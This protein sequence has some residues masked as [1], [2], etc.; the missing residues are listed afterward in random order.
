[1]EILSYLIEDYIRCKG[2]LKTTLS[3]DNRI[4]LRERLKISEAKFNTTLSRLR[5]KKVIN[6]LG[7][8]KNYLVYPD[9]EGLSISF[10]LKMYAEKS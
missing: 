7:I 1:M 8:N 5:S 9:S 3:Y 2:N 6:D 4:S 10:D